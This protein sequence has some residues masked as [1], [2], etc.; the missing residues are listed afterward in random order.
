VDVGEQHGGH[1]VGPAR[2]HA[3]VDGAPHRLDERGERGRRSRRL[4]VGRAELGER[5]GEHEEFAGNPDDPHL[6]AWRCFNRAVGTGGDVGIWHETYRVPAG[7]YECV[8]NNMPAFGLAAATAHV[9]VARRG[10]RARDRLARTS[11]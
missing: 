2:Q 10:E 8:Y 1:V 11:G 5:A 7:G 9:P 4:F 3:W 6:E